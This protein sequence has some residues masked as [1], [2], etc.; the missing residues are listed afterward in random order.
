[1]NGDG[2][3]YV[4]ALSPDERGAVLRAIRHELE[5]RENDSSDL[6]VLELR[7]AVERVLRAPL[8]TR[9]RA[10]SAIN[11]SRVERVERS[12]A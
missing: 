2:L 8:T 1:M 10:S 3:A 5:W 7:R 9:G 4:L 12:R 11:A 6:V